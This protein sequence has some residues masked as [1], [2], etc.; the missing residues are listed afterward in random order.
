[1]AITCPA[2]I[3]KNTDP[4]VC[5]AV[6]SWA[7]PAASDNCPGVTTS[8]TPASGSTFAKGTTTVDCTATDTSGH[9]ATCSF[10][11]TVNDNQPPT[12]TCPANITTTT[13]TGADN[14]SGDCQA[15]VTFAASASDNCPGSSISCSRSEER[16]VGRGR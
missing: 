8:C 12:A 1:P 16:R 4:G 13:S 15:Q 14:A 5:S 3:T 9:T 7:A 2:N 10:T 11:V 6:V